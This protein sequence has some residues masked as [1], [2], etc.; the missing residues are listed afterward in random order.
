MHWLTTFGGTLALTLLCVNTAF[1]WSG[2][3]LLIRPPLSPESYEECSQMAQK[4]SAVIDRLAAEHEACLQSAG[5]SSSSQESGPGGCSKAQCQSVHTERD[6]ATAAKQKAQDT[7]QQRVAEFQKRKH[8]EEER[9]RAEEQ[10]RADRRAATEER[11]HQREQRTQENAQR[12]DKEAREREERRQHE[13][14]AARA[15]EKERLDLVKKAYAARDELAAV[16]E[17]ARDPVG[18]VEGRIRSKLEENVRATPDE[19]GQSD[20]RFIQE[21]T[22]EFNSLGVHDNPFAEAVSGAALDEIGRQHATTL[23]KLDRLGEQIQ[24]FTP[25]ELPKSNPFGPATSAIRPLPSAPDAATAPRTVD[26]D[27]PSTASTSPRQTVTVEQETSAIP[28]SPAS[29]VT[30]V[31]PWASD[32]R[33]ATPASRPSHGTAPSPRTYVD[34]ETKTEFVIPAGHVLYRD[35]T[36]RKLRVVRRGTLEQIPP[37]SDRPEAGAGGCGATGLGI[38]TPECERKRQQNPFAVDRG[39]P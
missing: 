19:Q 32:V 28:N 27:T 34:P 26:I 3:Y 24:D 18:A 35:P 31:N 30:R 36:T 16:V 29:P 9:R 5:T 6:N 17:T 15:K 39:A 1:A 38:I 20:Y 13:Q 11:E 33:E 10:R 22:K 37:S 21:R 8:A 23:G 2:E 7:C 25:G 14:E 12:R 4:F